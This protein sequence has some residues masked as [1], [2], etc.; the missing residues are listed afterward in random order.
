[1]L[2]VTHIVP[3]FVTKVDFVSVGP[4]GT[5]DVPWEEWE[6]KDMLPAVLRWADWL[7]LAPIVGTM[8]DEAADPPRQ[9]QQGKKGGRGMRPRRRA[10]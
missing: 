5:R 4:W 9:N 2:V 7:D 6:K 3:H 10:G 8:L 1:M